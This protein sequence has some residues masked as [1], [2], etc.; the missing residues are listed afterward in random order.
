MKRRINI[1]YQV[2]PDGQKM[3]F[4]YVMEGKKQLKAKYFSV[5]EKRNF[6]EAYE[7]ACLAYIDLVAEFNLPETDPPT[8]EKIMSRKHKPK[9]STLGNLEEFKKLIDQAINLSSV[10]EVEAILKASLN[11][12]EDTKVRKEK[13]AAIKHTANKKIA[14]AILE[15]R[16]NGID[17]EAP[18]KEIAQLMK[19]LS[20]V[21]ARI[22]TP[23]KGVY[24]L[25][26]ERWD[27]TGHPPATFIRY[28]KENDADLEDLRIA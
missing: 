4:A 25:N 19:E 24:V 26:G 21:P 2:K 9:V 1:S 8:I 10:S 27:G 17:M 14:L 7:E 22:K 3:F 16:R 20:T 11:H 5:G 28:C 12:I 23:C 13:E 15:A 18:N 6:E